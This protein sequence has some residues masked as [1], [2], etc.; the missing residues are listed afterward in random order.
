MNYR[1][2]RKPDRHVIDHN[3]NTLWALVVLL[4][5]LFL[6]GISVYP[7][8]FSVTIA[9][10]VAALIVCIIL[11]GGRRKKYLAAKQ[12]PPMQMQ[13]QYIHPPVLKEAAEIESLMTGHSD[14][15]ALTYPQE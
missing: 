4:C 8:W 11:R 5:L 1:N 7:A 10:A 9:L 15:P 14:V 2:Y 6:F 12:I 13:S 3:G